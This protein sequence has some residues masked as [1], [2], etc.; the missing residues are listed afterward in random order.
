MMNGQ[1]RLAKDRE[2]W[3]AIATA[4]IAEHL[5]VRAILFNDVKDVLDRQLKSAFGVEQRP[6]VIDQVRPCALILLHVVLLDNRH[7]SLE[8]SQNVITRA[9]G[10][11]AWRTCGIR[12]AR[13]N[14]FGVQNKQSWCVS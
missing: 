11:G 4:Q 1:N 6:A 9:A 8:Q 3:I 2:L 5:I 7:R 14:T 12:M 10:R 13:L